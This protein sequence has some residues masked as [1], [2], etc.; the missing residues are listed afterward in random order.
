MRPRDPL[1]EPPLDL[2][3]GEL[4]LDPLEAL[5]PLEEERPPDALRE[6]AERPELSAPRE[7]LALR[8]F[9]A[10]R[11]LEAP[12]ALEELRLLADRLMSLRDPEL[13]PERPLAPRELSPRELLPLLAFIPPLLRLAMLNLPVPGATTLART[14]H[15]VAPSSRQR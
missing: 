6:L 11:P 4:P 10:L 12:R 8:E 5:R 2:F 1:P 3:R 7:L 13:E 9:S 15:A 14:T